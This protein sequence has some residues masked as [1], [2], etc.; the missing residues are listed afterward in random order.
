MVKVLI[1]GSGFQRKQHRKI[2]Q[3]KESVLFYTSVPNLAE[4]EC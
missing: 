2:E 4:D 1:N 3:E